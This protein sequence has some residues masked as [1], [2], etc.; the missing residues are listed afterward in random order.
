MI[1]KGDDDLICGTDEELVKSVQYVKKG[2][3]EFE[4]LKH[5]QYET[6]EEHTALSDTVFK[7]VF[8]D[9]TSIITNY[10]ETDYNADDKTGGKTGNET[11]SKIVKPMSY[12]VNPPQHR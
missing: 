2:F 7:T 4:Q 1:K 8:S 12:T 3:D 11:E 5:I 10:G 6:M 9:G